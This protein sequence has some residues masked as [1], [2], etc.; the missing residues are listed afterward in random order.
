MLKPRFLSL[1]DVSLRDIPQ[2]L[3]EFLVAIHR[4]LGG[5]FS[6]LL[7]IF[8]ANSLTM[9]FP[10]ISSPQV[11]KPYRGSTASSQPPKSVIGNRSGTTPLLDSSEPHRVLMACLSCAETQSSK[12]QEARAVD[13]DNEVPNEGSEALIE[14]PDHNVT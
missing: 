12:T 4:C 9:R 13:P 5:D 14:E 3:R 2:E 10:Q 1:G 7:L 8:W 6:S 11:T